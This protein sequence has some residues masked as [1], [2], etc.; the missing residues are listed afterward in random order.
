MDKI[1][2]KID[3]YNIFTNIVP[4]YVFLIFNL[5]Y[6]QISCLNIGEKIII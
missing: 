3:S 2:E 1:I 6:F 5:Y 4:G